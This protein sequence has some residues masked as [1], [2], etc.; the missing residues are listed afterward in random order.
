MARSP[1]FSQVQVR[2][3]T[4]TELLINLQRK[5]EGVFCTLFCEVVP[6]CLNFLVYPLPKTER[7]P[8]SR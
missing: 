6:A 3:A 5:E 7:D 8:N 2:L 1:V 4:F